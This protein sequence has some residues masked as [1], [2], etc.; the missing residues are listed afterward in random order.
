LG[1]I[2]CD[3]LD[4]EARNYVSLCGGVDAVAANVPFPNPAIKEQL[5]RVRFDRYN[6]EVPYPGSA[7]IANDVAG[8]RVG[9][10]PF[11]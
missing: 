9:F 4:P 6:V 1:H 8:I 2:Q 3:A 7:E 10:E 5:K 11:L